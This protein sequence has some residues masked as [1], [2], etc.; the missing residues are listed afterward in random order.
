MQHISVPPACYMQAVSSR[1]RTAPELPQ[2][3]P[4]ASLVTLYT[5]NFLNQ[6]LLTYFGL[7]P[8][9]YVAASVVLPVAA[10]KGPS[11]AR[12]DAHSRL[13]LAL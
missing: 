10:S 13:Q 2:W 8:R 9:A 5:V 11:F 12:T 6:L 4:L 1:P 7:V 3:N